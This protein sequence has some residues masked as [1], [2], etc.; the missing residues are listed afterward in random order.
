MEM[1]KNNPNAFEREMESLPPLPPRVTVAFR[2][3][4]CDCIWTFGI[5]SPISFEIF[6]AKNKECYN[7]GKSNI[8]IDIIPVVPPPIQLE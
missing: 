7:C 1:K 2:C 6:Y 5:E 8:E 3:R 4:D